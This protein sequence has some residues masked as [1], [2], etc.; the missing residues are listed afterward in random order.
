MEMDKND[1]KHDRIK[2]GMR[3]AF[4]VAV[5]LLKMS[6][7]T[8]ELGFRPSVQLLSRHKRIKVSST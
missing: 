1:K 5:I 2:M 4:V 8:D 6:C 7:P 3:E